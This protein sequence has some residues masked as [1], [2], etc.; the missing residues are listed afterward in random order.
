MATNGH[1]AAE[2]P[3]STKIS[4]AVGGAINGAKSATTYTIP[5]IIG[6]KDVHTSSTFDV[7]A[8][9]T[10]K[11]LYKCSSVSVE[12]AIQAVE[13]AEKAFPAWRATLPGKRRDI[14]LK[15]ADILDKRAQELGKYMEDETGSTAFWAGGFNVPVSSDGLRDIAGRI[16]G[17][18]GMVPTMADPG[19]TALILKEPF[20][21]V[22]GIA[23]WYVHSISK[24]ISSSEQILVEIRAI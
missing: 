14:F 10:R 24:V 20:G 19:K 15:A 13:A 1:E 7:I 18:V 3:L 2:V 4:D 22:L 17:L 23:P 6:G 16:S 11:L 5:A 12:E 8:P 9:A 21:V